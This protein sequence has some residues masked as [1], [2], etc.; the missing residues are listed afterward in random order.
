[1]RTFL[2][3]NIKLDLS[4]SRGRISRSEK[5]EKLRVRRSEE[6]REGI[7]GNQHR[8]RRKAL[9][10]GET[11]IKGRIKGTERKAEREGQREKGGNEKK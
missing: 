4:N 10:N 8:E 3:S 7:K 9:G 1:M 6:R 2:R 5:S 11:G